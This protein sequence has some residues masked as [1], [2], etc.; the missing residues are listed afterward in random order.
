M[1][2]YHKNAG[3]EVGMTNL[4]MIAMTRSG[5]NFNNILSWKQYKYINAESIKPKEYL[6]FIDKHKVVGETK[7]VILLR[8]LLNWLSSYL[9]IQLS[10]E[11]Y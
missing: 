6:Y 4:M 5:H 10:I 2:F 1:G 3:K 8:D 7:N 11:K 9:K